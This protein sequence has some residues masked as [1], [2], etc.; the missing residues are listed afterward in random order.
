M[1]SISGLLIGPSR[2]RLAH[3]WQTSIRRLI[4]SF[5]LARE[6]MG[7]EWRGSVVIDNIWIAI[8][9]VRRLLG[10]SV[11]FMHFKFPEIVDSRE[12]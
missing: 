8:L 5:A 9:V 6:G 11:E 2:T 10:Q 7:G 12:R 1:K 3:E 4:K